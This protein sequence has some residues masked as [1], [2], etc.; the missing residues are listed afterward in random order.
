MADCGTLASELRG[1]EEGIV[2]PVCRGTMLWDWFLP[3]G[4]R[5]MCWWGRDVQLWFSLLLGTEEIGVLLP[6]RRKGHTITLLSELIRLQQNFSKKKWRTVLLL[7]KGRVLQH[8]F[9][10]GIFGTSLQYTKVAIVN[11][12]ET[13][14]FLIITIH[15]KT[16]TADIFVYLQW[17]G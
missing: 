1:T 13:K 8:F 7:G 14:G 5:R 3:R 6:E 2:A 9:E 12:P 4:E 16:S 17:K 11:S 10:G 15:I